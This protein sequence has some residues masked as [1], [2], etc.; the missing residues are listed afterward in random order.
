LTPPHE[1]TK[2]SFMTTFSPL[3]AAALLISALPLR[4]DPLESSA[5]DAA[6]AAK[7]PAGYCVARELDAAGLDGDAAA[8][9]T[10]GANDDADV[11]AADEEI[12]TAAPSKAKRPTLAERRDT[13]AKVARFIEFFRSPGSDEVVTKAFSKVAPKSQVKFFTGRGRVLN[14]TYRTLAV[15][16]YT[17]AIKQAGAC[18][19]GA[20]ARRDM[21]NAKDGL[22]VDPKTGKFSEWFSRLAGKKGAPGTTEAG[23]E[24][25]G[26]SEDEAAARSGPSFEDNYQRLLARQQNLT[27]ELDAVKEPKAKA[28]LMCRRARGYRILALGAL[29]RKPIAPRGKSTLAASDLDASESEVESATDADGSAPEPVAAAVDVDAG[30][31]VTN[32]AWTMPAS[33]TALTAKELYRKIA[34]SVVAIR[35]S[36]GGPG[37]VFG[38][39]SLISDEGN[40]RVLT[41]AHVVWNKAANKPQT[42]VTVYFKPT[43]ITGDRA[44][45]L[46]NGIPATIVRIDRAKD[47][48]LLSLSRRPAKTALIEFG[49][50]SKVETG[51]P[52]FAIGHP[53]QGGLWT[54]TQGVVGAVKANMTGVKGKDAFQTDA[55]INRGNS[56]GPLLDVTG[57][58][59]GVNTLIARRADDG[60]AITS[61]NFSLKIGFVKNWLSESKGVEA[62]E[63]D[64]A[65]DVADAAAIDEKSDV[66]MGDGSI[67]TVSRPFDIDEIADAEDVTAAAD[68]EKAADAAPS[69]EAAA[70]DEAAA[71]AKGGKILTPKRP[72]DRD[73]MIKQGLKKI[74]SEPKAVGADA[75]KSGLEIVSIEGSDAD[76]GVS[77]VAA[78]ETTESAAPATETPKPIAPTSRMKHV[79]HARMVPGGCLKPDGSIGLPTKPGRAP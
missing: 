26:A 70:P 49:D 2:L 17:Y 68:A 43:K 7:A 71:P 3:L 27:R 15:I 75:I 6:A 30:D 60:L 73:S 38:T 57:R 44:K 24:E 21:L 10:A 72:Y 45:D 58:Q 79:H 59:I 62:G 48:A 69:E 61:V 33:K 47:L 63:V 9:E 34:P 1:V 31:E 37:G 23:L 29:L 14:T 50:D 20:K 22:F 55:S 67:L 8:L 53:E 42:K 28:A 18:R 41:N 35:S 11:D 56:G 4:A 5:E 32:A 51:D 36:S 64:D 19:E 74:G 12:E 54:L 52:V 25:G 77:D 66:E 40:G 16:D 13:F 39:G 78:E 76:G 65:A 46:A